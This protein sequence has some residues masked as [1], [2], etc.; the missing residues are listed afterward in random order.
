MINDINNEKKMDDRLSV[1]RSFRCSG[2]FSRH[3]STLNLQKT[4]LIYYSDPKGSVNANDWICERG[5]FA[6]TDIRRI[7]RK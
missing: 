6:E 7:T 2:G 5:A 3:G 4:Y 1:E